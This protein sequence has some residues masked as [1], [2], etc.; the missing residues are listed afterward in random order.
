ML[1]FSELEEQI[2]SLPSNMKLIDLKAKV[3]FWSF[4][5]AAQLLS[6]NKIPF[7]TVYFKQAPDLWIE[8]QDF[9]IEKLSILKAV[10]NYTIG[11]KL[12]LY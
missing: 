2:S 4:N 9:P 3:A 1:T 7:S 8:I 6:E 10:A 11:F 5:S 12:T